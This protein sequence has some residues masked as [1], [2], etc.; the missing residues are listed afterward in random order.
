MG[1]G[2]AQ[3]GYPR[4]AGKEAS[5]VSLEKVKGHPL[6][7][8]LSPSFGGCLFKAR[9]LAF[10]GQLA[11]RPGM[12]KGRARGPRVTKALGSCREAPEALLPTSPGPGFK[13]SL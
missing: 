6:V 4:Q 13:A 9:Y 12:R 7:R 3:G 8:R 5:S 1:P 10:T 11:R 2:E